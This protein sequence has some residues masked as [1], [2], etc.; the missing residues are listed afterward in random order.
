MRVFK[1]IGSKDRFVEM[2]QNVN[3][4]KLNEDV[5]TGLESN[6]ILQD[7]Y[8]KFKSGDIKIDHTSTYIED[9]ETYV[10]VECSIDNV[11]CKFIFNIIFDESDQDDVF[12][13]SEVK[14]IKFE[15]NS[16]DTSF[17]LEGN[18]LDEFNKN[19]SGEFY[20]LIKNYIDVDD[21]AP[22]IDETYEELAKKIDSFPYGTHPDDI[23]TSKNYGDR[24]PANSKLR[25]DKSKPDYYVPASSVNEDYRNETDDY[26]RETDDEPIA[27]TQINYTDTKVEPVSNE[28]GGNLGSQHNVDDGEF[29]LPAEGYDSQSQPD[30]DPEINSEPEG[31]PDVEPEPEVNPDDEALVGG[32]A[33]GA[34]PM[35]FNPQ[36][37]LKGIE[38]EMEHTND[39]KVALEIAMDHL[40]EDP[41]YYTK[42]EKCLGHDDEQSE[43]DMMKDKLLGY[44]PKNVGDV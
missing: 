34:E 21:D 18:N 35:E 30:I 15:Y 17:T 2:F 42:H 11:K 43:D 29:D 3:K 31:E 7:T 39:P 6:Q 22:E 26:E 1:E 23:Q 13:V 9:E 44:K 41:E 38:V 12:N 25:V 32:E 20:E 28:V 4:M 14:L 5:D 37:I 10:E 16:Q 27:K 8:S 36:Q 33:D 24:S 40:A 19:Y